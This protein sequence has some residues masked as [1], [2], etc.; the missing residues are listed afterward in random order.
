M[1]VCNVR[2]R[3]NT[4]NISSS[5][6]SKRKS[7]VEHIGY[8]QIYQSITNI[9]LN[10]ALD[11]GMQLFCVSQRN[12]RNHMFTAHAH[13]RP[14][15]WSSRW[16]ARWR[17]GRQVKTMLMYLYLYYSYVHVRRSERRSGGGA[18]D[19]TSFDDTVTL[20]SLLKPQ[21]IWT[22]FPLHTLSFS[23]S[24]DWGDQDR[25]TR[26]VVSTLDTSNTNIRVV[27]KVQ[28]TGGL[29]HLAGRKR[30][31]KEDDNKLS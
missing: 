11:H 15:L 14:E 5:R 4:E 12:E 21:I 23:L 8:R 17:S 3:Q 31:G 27:V 25:M 13:H 10:W 1:A 16:L 19:L 2:R 29:I 24:L 30:A 7:A 9:C 6:R 18:T 28:K 20:A 22:P 26:K